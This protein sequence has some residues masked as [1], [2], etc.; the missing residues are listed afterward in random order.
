MTREKSD[1]YFVFDQGQE[2]QVAGQ[3]RAA[4]FRNLLPP[5]PVNRGRGCGFFHAG[6]SGSVMA[7][8]PLE[9]KQCSEKPKSDLQLE[10]REEELRNL[11]AM[12][13]DTSRCDGGTP[14]RPCSQQYTCTQFNLRFQGGL[15]DSADWRAREREGGACREHV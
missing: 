11:R 13:A 1:P 6:L 2:L 7:F 10:S 3:A 12:I 15:D 5:R 8:E 4:W 9:I 14:T